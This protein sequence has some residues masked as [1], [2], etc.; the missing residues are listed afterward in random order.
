VN[1]SHHRTRQRWI[2]DQVLNVLADPVEEQL[3]GI[4]DLTDFPTT[5]VNK[6]SAAS[7]RSLT[8]TMLATRLSASTR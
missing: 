1:T 2:G 4:G 3:H 6:S 8:M 7:L 5:A